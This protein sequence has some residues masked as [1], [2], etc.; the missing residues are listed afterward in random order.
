MRCWELD[1]RWRKVLVNAVINGLVVFF[2]ELGSKLVVDGKVVPDLTVPVVVATVTGLIKLF[3]LIQAESD[4]EMGTQTG[5]V[6]K[7]N[8]VA[9]VLKDY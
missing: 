6:K 5:A 3:S 2:V 1:A 7:T 9:A 4:K 8:A